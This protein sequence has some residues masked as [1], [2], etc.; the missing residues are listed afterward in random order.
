MTQSEPTEVA[1]LKLAL[2][3]VRSELNLEKEWRDREID[4]LLKNADL[5]DRAVNLLLAA[6][7]RLRDH[8]NHELDRI[9]G[10]LNQP[11]LDPP[12]NQKS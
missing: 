2:E 6:I 11:R 10:E 9:E 3:H 4:R 5:R 8:Y 1:D 7:K 12:Q